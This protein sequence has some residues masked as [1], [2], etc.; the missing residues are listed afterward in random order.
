MIYGSGTLAATTTT[1]MHTVSQACY[2][3]ELDIEVL[4]P[5]GTDATVEIAVSPNSASSPNPDDYIEKGG[6]A[7]A[8][9]GKIEHTSK[10]VNPGSKVFVKGPIGLVVQVRGKAVTKLP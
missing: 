6:I 2:Y 5:N 9:G 10:R 4:N 1:L 3:A 8:N 7:A